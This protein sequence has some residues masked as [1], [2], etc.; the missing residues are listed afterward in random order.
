MAVASVVGDLEEV[1][2]L[3]GLV[4]SLDATI[5]RAELDKVIP[6]RVQT[7]VVEARVNGGEGLRNHVALVG[8]R[9]TLSVQVTTNIFALRSKTRKKMFCWMI[10]VNTVVEK[11]KRMC[12]VM[13]GQ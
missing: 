7:A 11:W 2:S 1:V 6:H 3:H 8:V 13:S 5:V 10:F 12:T 9:Q 4:L